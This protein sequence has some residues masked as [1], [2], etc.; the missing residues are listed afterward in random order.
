LVEVIHLV[1]ETWDGRGWDRFDA[2]LRV[3]PEGLERA[4]KSTGEFTRL[5]IA[6]PREPALQPLYVTFP[7]TIASTL[8]FAINAQFDPVLSRESLQPTPWNRW[9]VARL[10][11]LVVEVARHMLAVSPLLGWGVVPLP[12][13]G[14]KSAWLTRDL[15]AALARARKTIAET[16]GLLIAGAI[17]PLHEIAYEN[18]SL[19]DLLKPDDLSTV[20]DG[21][22]GVPLSL[23]D[24]AGRW[25][26]VLKALGRSIEV[27]LS[28]L[29]G[30]LAGEDGFAGKP[31][32]WF[33]AVFA[34][35]VEGQMEGSIPSDDEIRDA[36]LIV[37]R[38]GKRHRA[39][40][41]SAAA[42]VL[43]TGSETDPFARAHGLVIELNGAFAGDGPEA[44]TARRWLSS[45]STLVSRIDAAHLL[46][47]YANA[48]AAA[49]REI[50]PAEFRHLRD[51]FEEVTEV[52]AASLGPRVGAA[53]LLRGR[54]YEGKPV[55]VR[56][57]A[58]DA[59]LPQRYE[60]E[61]LGWAMA[62]GRTPG[63][64][65]VDTEY[66]DQ[67]KVK[68][69]KSRGEVRA[70]G[71]RAFLTLLGVLAVPRLVHVTAPAWSGKHHAWASAQGLQIFDDYDSQDLVSVLVDITA[72]SERGAARAGALYRCI[73]RNWDRSLEQKSAA[74]AG[75]KGRHGFNER[76]KV[77][78]SWLAL[79]IDRSWMRDELGRE[80]RPK[81]LIVRSAQ[82][83]AIYGAG[84]R[85]AAEL[86][87]EDLRSSFATALEIEQRAPPIR[88][89]EQL[90]R[91]RSG[92]EALDQARVT[93]CY[94]A[95]AGQCPP[96]SSSNIL[97]QDVEDMSV[98]TLRGKFGMNPK[99]KGLLYDA[100]ANT[101]RAPSAFYRGPDIFRGRRPRVPSSLDLLPL[102]VALGVREPTVE[103]CLKE[104]EAAAKAPPTG[105][106][107]GFLVNVYRHIQ[108]KGGGGRVRPGSL[109]TL[110]VVCGDRWV[111]ERPV[112]VIE[113]FE[114]SP[115][116]IAR[117]G[118]LQ[119][120]TPPCDTQSVRDLMR[121]LGVREIRPGVT[122][123]SHDRIDWEDGFA[124]TRFRSA[125][126]EFQDDAA[127]NAPN[128]HEAIEDWPTLRDAEVR[129]HGVGLLR[130]TLTHS[131][132]PVSGVTIAE[133]AFA[134]LR[135]GCIYVETPEDLADVDRGGRAVATFF[136][137]EVRR[138]VALLWMAAWSRSETARR[139]PSN[140]PG[141]ATIR[142]T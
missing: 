4:E 90:E 123:A 93:R 40:P 79:L 85:Y 131:A 36:R 86:R 73:A 136:S 128:V 99:G 112:Y 72:D 68:G 120:W 119:I 13:E 125:A 38:T 39:E 57:R 12:G 23:R 103:D 133:H 67:L 37:D 89:I 98:K 16:A 9:L 87:M 30:A 134:D 8:P 137:P 2:V 43:V 60:R 105:D 58:V 111:R 129:L 69:R 114:R 56:T 19:A 83:E 126:L 49:P 51:L 48:Y 142:S 61:V 104:I 10:G 5:S 71:A 46:S 118:E 81:D 24:P 64:V 127:R 22:H 11:E 106:L 47:A 91:M 50:D 122:I 7:T 84:A 52:E 75:R 66:E 113:G 70:R 27:D 55:E 1:G 62:A 95:L 102:W 138:E 82:A 141:T 92:E 96:L 42:V 20:L 101:W 100:E 28:D 6:L 140:S 139:R 76:L 45:Q 34:H 25:R 41:R 54:R 94:L 17:V 74:R 63:L 97:E 110:P 33:V 124:R 14:V 115:E 88:L 21:S 130:L 117:A 80:A 32:A 135:D 78:A 31:A 26:S 44:V 116:L 3:P 15:E 109:S 132:L 53:I 29:L 35:S 65:W 59:Y 18:A 107:D 77:P 121:L 108:A